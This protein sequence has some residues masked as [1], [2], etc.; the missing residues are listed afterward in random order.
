MPLAR[1]TGG[2]GRVWLVDERS[3]VAVQRRAKCFF[4]WA[5]GNEA[6]RVF[7]QR[8]SHGEP[9]DDDRE[10]LCRAVRVAQMPALADCPSILR[11][12][13][14]GGYWDS[15]F[16]FELADVSLDRLLATDDLGRADPEAILG[17]VTEAL[18]ATHGAGYVHCDVQPANVFCVAGRWKLGDFGGAVRIGDPVDAM[19]RDRRFVAPGMTFGMPATPEL[20]EHSVGVL[21]AVLRSGQL[22]SLSA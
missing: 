22:D 16:V 21:R 10:H 3:E 11:V 15:Y 8:V 5:E 19:P 12:L 20:D 1:V 7:V 17:A 6:D 18:V 9:F 13:G 14:S 2:D 4:G